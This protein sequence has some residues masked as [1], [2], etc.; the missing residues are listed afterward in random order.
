MTFYSHNV[1]KSCSA[2]YDIK[3]NQCLADAVIEASV[4]LTKMSGDPSNTRSTTVKRLPP[5]ESDPKNFW[6]AQAAASSEPQLRPAP[7]GLRRPWALVAGPAA[8]HR[9]P[10]RAMPGTPAPGA[11]VPLR[12]AGASVPRRHQLDLGQD[13]V[14][15]QDG[16]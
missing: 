4:S 10:I 13:R 14:L 6:S 1:Q 16:A 2:A 7:R 3:R 15:V 12:A 5:V 9:L 8:A 11:I